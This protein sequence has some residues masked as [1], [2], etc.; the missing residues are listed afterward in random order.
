MPSSGPNRSTKEAKVIAEILKKLPSEINGGMVA[1]LIVNIL[2]RYGMHGEWEKIVD[3]VDET[4]QDIE[5]VSVI[6][7][8]EVLMN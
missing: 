6:N 2:Y 4:M 1:A 7:I 3:A 5:E 8:S